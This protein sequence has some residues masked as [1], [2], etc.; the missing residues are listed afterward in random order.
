MVGTGFSDYITETD[1]S[2]ATCLAHSIHVILWGKLRK[3]GCP[4]GI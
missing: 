1:F 3:V 2:S 4:V